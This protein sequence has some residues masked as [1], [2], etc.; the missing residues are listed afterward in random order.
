[1]FETIISLVK[2]IAFV[3]FVVATYKSAQYYKNHANSYE[4]ELKDEILKRE[5][6]QRAV[7]HFES[8]E[9]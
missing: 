3:M 9:K 5:R 7:E 4:N 2:V 1:M 6:R 8:L